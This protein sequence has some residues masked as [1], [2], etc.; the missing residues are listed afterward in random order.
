MNTT[1]ICY[2]DSV[3][4]NLKY[5]YILE[6]CL[7]AYVKYMYKNFEIG[8]RFCNKNENN[9]NLLC[10]FCRKKSKIF[11]ILE[12]FNSLRKIYV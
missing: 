3:E 1:W 2:A 6:V 5:F 7:T 12:V 4:R 9:L 11:F 8:F 10:R